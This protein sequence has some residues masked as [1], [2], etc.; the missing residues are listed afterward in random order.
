MKIRALAAIG[1]ASALLLTGCG[2]SSGG[3][4]SRPSASAP[5]TLTVLAA[6]SLTRRSPRSAS[7][8][9]RPPQGSR[10]SSTTR[11]RRTAMTMYCCSTQ[12]VLLAWRRRAGEEAGAAPRV[13]R[14]RGRCGSPNAPIRA[15]EAGQLGVV[16]NDF[17]QAFVEW[18]QQAEA[19]GREHRHVERLQGVPARRGL[20]FRAE[21]DLHQGALRIA[22]P[23]R[24]ARAAAG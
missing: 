19:A 16:G 13:G 22:R 2:G 21:T 5:Q 20:L 14:A 17:P 3:G 4:T 6:A 15:E 1:A 10:S 7:S 24:A 9:D 8:S 18:R 12:L 23:E 11:A